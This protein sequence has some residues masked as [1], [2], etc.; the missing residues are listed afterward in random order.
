MH[1]KARRPATLVL[2][3]LLLGATAPP[4]AAQSSAPSAGAASIYTCIDDQGRRI[5]ADR[6]IASCTAK[7]QRVLNK[8]GSLKAVQPPTLTADERAEK[9]AQERK[10]AEARAAQA[11]AVRRD[12]NLL[13]RYPNETSHRKAREAALDTVRAATKATERR[14][15]DLAT[16]RKPLLAEAEFYEGKS[17]PPKLRSQLDA[18]DAATAAQREA[19]VNQEAE[20][21]RVN[22]L[23]DA[24]LAR[25]KQLWAGAAPGS[26]GS[27]ASAHP[28]S[29]AAAP[30]A[31]GAS[32]LKAS[33]LR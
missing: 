14:L 26:S 9:E 24:E 1:A 22:R 5:T 20:L 21:D 23:Y 16:E 13:A 25:L 19:A 8:D 15:Q 3:L 6:P 33:N 12:R 27:M 11:E 7:E 30:L 4:L 32:S 29:P 28:A 17:L 31:A 18:N 2:T 10:Q